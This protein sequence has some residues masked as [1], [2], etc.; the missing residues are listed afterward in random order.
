[1]YGGQAL[2]FRFSTLY[3]PARH[4]TTISFLRLSLTFLSTIRPSARCSL[5]SIHSA[6][7]L[8]FF[9]PSTACVYD[10]ILCSIYY[11]A[12]HPDPVPSSFSFSSARA[13]AT[14]YATTPFMSSTNHLK[15]ARPFLLELVDP[16][17]LI[18]PG[19]WI[20]FCVPV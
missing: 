4:S 12:P 3:I 15:P 11:L 6:V 20:F 19:F 1:M 10:T 9:L 8:I 18:P 16:S 2:E 7:R 17:V 5:A 14:A 13:P